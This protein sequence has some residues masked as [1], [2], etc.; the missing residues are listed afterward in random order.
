M[1]SNQQLHRFVLCL[2]LRH[3]RSLA[4]SDL[5]PRIGTRSTTRELVIWLLLIML[6][7]TS[8]V[9]FLKEILQFS[10]IFPA[11]AHNEDSPVYGKD[12]ANQN[13]SQEQLE[14][15]HHEQGLAPLLAK[16]TSDHSTQTYNQR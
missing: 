10:L 5:A 7:I 14:H 16:T 1:P 4:F 8:H 11:L 13:V 9:R 2:I 6:L 3:P 12:P 15:A